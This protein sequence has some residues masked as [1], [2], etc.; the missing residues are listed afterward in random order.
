MSLLQ[1]VSHSALRAARHFWPK[2]FDG[3]SEEGLKAVEEG[4][5]AVRPVLVHGY[6]AMIMVC[7]AALHGVA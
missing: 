6:E 4:M 1:E 2:A 3:I 5:E 7:A